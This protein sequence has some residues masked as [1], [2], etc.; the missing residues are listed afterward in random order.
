M[1][2]QTFVSTYTQM[3]IVKIEVRG[4]AI[5]HTDLDDEQGKIVW[6]K[7]REIDGRA[8]EQALAGLKSWVGKCPATVVSVGYGD[9]SAIVKEVEDE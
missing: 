9:S 1:A 2:K 6:E 3:V 8:G 5:T 7:L 4:I